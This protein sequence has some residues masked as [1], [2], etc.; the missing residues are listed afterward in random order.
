MSIVTFSGTGMQTA[1]MI[2]LKERMASTRGV[3]AAKG[4]A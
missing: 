2:G 3:T 4:M 1:E